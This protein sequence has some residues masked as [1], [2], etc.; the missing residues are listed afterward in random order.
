[1]L[2]AF[3]L[4][5]SLPAANVGG[6]LPFKDGLPIIELHVDGRVSLRHYPAPDRIFC[7]VTGQVPGT[8]EFSVSCP[9]G[10]DHVLTIEDEFGFIFDGEAYAIGE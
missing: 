1:M 4:A 2:A 7:T 9:D 8:L 5:V 3:L 6:Y 10:L